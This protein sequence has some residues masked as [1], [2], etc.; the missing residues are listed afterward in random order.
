MRNKAD[1]ATPLVVCLVLRVLGVAC[2][3]GPAEAQ[4]SAQSKGAPAKQYPPTAFGEPFDWRKLVGLLVVCGGLVLVS[5][6]G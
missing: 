1:A 5:Q 2:T 4:G 6:S 3:S